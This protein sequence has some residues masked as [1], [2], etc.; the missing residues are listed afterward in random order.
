MCTVNS[1]GSSSIECPT[2]WI[3][4]QTNIM[5]I[6]AYVRVNYDMGYL[7]GNRLINLIPFSTFNWLL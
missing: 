3:K 7:E 1:K 2:V 5:S 6:I 4:V